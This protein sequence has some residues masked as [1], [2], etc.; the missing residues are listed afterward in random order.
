MLDHGVSPRIHGNHKRTPHNTLSLDTYQLAM[1]FLEAY[2]DKHAIKDNKG[3]N[4]SEVLHLPKS[5]TKKIIHDAY[6]NHM[7]TITNEPGMITIYN[8]WSY[9]GKTFINIFELQ[10]K[11]TEFFYIR[12][13]T[14][15]SKY[16]KRDMD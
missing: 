8:F 7:K 2:L 16:I 13:I 3:P 15:T 1:R 14:S 5:I 4:K 11:N 6:L 10:G 12:E 9:F